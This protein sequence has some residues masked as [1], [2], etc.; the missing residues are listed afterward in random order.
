MISRLIRE[1][2]M[3]LRDWLLPVVL[4]RG[5]R[6][7]NHIVSWSEEGW[8]IILRTPESRWGADTVGPEVMIARA[9]LTSLPN[10]L[11]IWRDGELLADIQW[12]DNNFEVN[13]FH[14]SD[15][16]DAIH[17]LRPN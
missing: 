16:I 7:E 1:R 4:G 15:W 6:D 9:F 3:G 2:A 14:D 13:R 17:A 10:G 11:M 8:G 12:D 5:D